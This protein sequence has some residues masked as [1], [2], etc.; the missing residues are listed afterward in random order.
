MDLISKFEGIYV[1]AQCLLLLHWWMFVDALCLILSS[2]N[3]EW[4]PS[5]KLFFLHY[6]V[7]DFPI[8]E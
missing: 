2:Y 4:I 3:C 8:L 7:I 6:I 1:I 5:S